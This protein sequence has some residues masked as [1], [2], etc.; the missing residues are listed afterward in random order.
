MNT[1]PTPAPFRMGQS[2]SR[3]PI[4]PLRVYCP[5]ANSMNKS[6]ILEHIYLIMNNSFLIFEITRK[7]PTL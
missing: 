1:V 3:A 2:L 6:G 5:T 4:G 7:E